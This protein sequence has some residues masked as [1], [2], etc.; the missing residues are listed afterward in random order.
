MPTRTCCSEILPGE[1]GKHCHH[2]RSVY[3][4]PNPKRNTHL[5][6]E[7][8]RC[9]LLLRGSL[10]VTWRPS[11]PANLQPLPAKIGRAGRDLRYRPC[12]FESW[13]LRLET[14]LRKRGKQRP[15]TEPGL[16]RAY[17][18]S[19]GEAGVGSPRGG[20]TWQQQ[21]YP[22]AAAPRLETAPNY[23][24]SK[25]NSTGA[26]HNRRTGAGENLLRP[27]APPSPRLALKTRRP[28]TLQLR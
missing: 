13:F 6:K 11:T 10:Y 19:P 25:G 12:P 26:A 23:G 21:A 18:A 8:R 7:G 1:I 4:R 24:F 16:R 20:G 28:S 15:D 17:R 3:G 14:R 9:D 27:R 2:L 22:G 5:T